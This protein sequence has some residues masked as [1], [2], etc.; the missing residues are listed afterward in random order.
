[1]EEKKITGPQVTKQTCSH[2]RQPLLPSS[3]IGEYRIVRVVSLNGEGITYLAQDSIIGDTVQVQEFFPAHM[4]RRSEDGNTLEPL[5]GCATNFKYFRAS[6]IDLY[7]TLQGTKDN[8]C[9]IPIIQILEQNATA[10]VVSEY[11][12]MTTLEEYLRLQGGRESWCKA[13]RYLLPL[14]HALSDL[15]KKG[16]THQ[17]LSPQNILLDEEGIPYLKGFCLSE[18]R[19][20][21]GDLDSEL[22][23]GYSAPEQYQADGWPGV[24]TDIYSL[25]AVCYRALTGV[26]PPEAPERKKKDSLCPACQLEEDIPENVSDALDVALQLGADK[27]FDSLDTMTRKLLELPS[28]NTA[29]FS[30]EREDIVDR[31]AVFPVRFHQDITADELGGTSTGE[32]VSRAKTG[33]IYIVVT[34]MATLLVLV[35]GAPQLYKHFNNVW[36]ASLGDTSDAL[37]DPQNQE[38]QLQ[39]VTSEQ[40]PHKVENFVGRKATDVTENARYQEWYYFETVEKYSDDFSE[41]MII[42]QSIDSGTEIKKKTTM[43]LYVSKGPE[44]QELPDF[45]GSTM[46]RAIAV[47]EEMGKQWKVVEGENS[48]VEPGEV[49]RTEPPAGTQLSKNSSETILLYVAKDNGMQDSEEDTDDGSGQGDNTK[50]DSTS[51]KKTLRKSSS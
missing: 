44:T 43:T 18:I 49:F 17:G 5:E 19:T 3:C 1:M 21:Q 30:M 28:S 46:E 36:T 16:I 8:A 7:Q 31:T 42:D 34:M 24:G 48:T 26:V 6:F 50:A 37:E 9:M 4:A 41:G 15:H 40:E 2:E 20:A 47:L 32:K 35:V 38:V 12:E 33:S 39:P 14:Y 25:A 10:Y 45:S 22:F 11:R 27:R 29:I 23:A 13:K 51:Q